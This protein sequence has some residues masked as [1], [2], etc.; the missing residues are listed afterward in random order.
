[1][2]R[3]AA[4]RVLVVHP[5]AELYGSDRMVLES[6][7]GAVEAGF[8]VVVALGEDGPLADRVR[9]AGARAEVLPVPVLRKS[10]LTPRGLLRLAVS[11]VRAVLPQARLLRR[12]RPSVLYVS[13][14]T[15]PTWPLVG[16]LIGARVVAHVHEAEGR[17]PAAVRWAMAAPLLACRTVLV[18]S[19]YARQTLVEAQPRLAGRSQVVLNGVEGPAGGPMARGPRAP[20]EPLRLLY[21]GRLSERKGVFVALDAL[22]L[23]LARGASVRLDLVGSTFG[24]HAD[25]AR[26]LERRL[27]DE[28]LLGAV[29]VHSF[30]DDVWSHLAACDALLVPSVL[31]EPFGNT[32][33]E[34]LLA[35]R[36]VV[37]SD[38]GGLPEAVQGASG[39][40][41]VTPGDA[42]ALAAAVQSLAEELPV[43]SERAAGGA[44]AAADRYAPGRYRAEVAAAL[45]RAAG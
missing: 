26:H 17:A 11:A 24:E 30:T 34:G 44:A 37:A 2:S 19:S 38:L 7:R 33:V 14:L 1:M 28:A 22:E 4:P 13:T 18:N 8:D 10:S 31:P 32:A 29:T 9:A 23:L 39:A 21:V 45:T 27:A 12:E 41:L 42:E 25:V 40:R 6:V 36:P 20:G 35:G 15:T 3:G 5:S 43:L 16:R